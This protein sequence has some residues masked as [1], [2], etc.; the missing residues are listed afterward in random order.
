MTSKHHKIF[1]FL[2]LLTIFTT[3]NSA[4]NKIEQVIYAEFL[5]K[6]NVCFYG[7]SDSNTNDYYYKIENPNL[8]WTIFIQYSSVNSF[9]LYDSKLDLIK[10]STISTSTFNFQ[11]D[12]NIAEYYLK[13]NVAPNSKY[14]FCYI[15]YPEK[16]NKIEYK[17]DEN[18]AYASYEI[19]TP[20]KFS[21]YLP[22]INSNFNGFRILNNNL[23]NYKK[24]KII[25]TG[26]YNDNS[27]NTFEIKD[28]FILKDYTYFPFKLTQ[29][30]IKKIKEAY[31]DVYLEYEGKNPNYESPAELLEIE[32]IEIKEKDKNDKSSLEKENESNISNSL[33]RLEGPKKKKR[34]IA[35][36]EIIR[37]NRDLRRKQ[38]SYYY[39]GKIGDKKPVNFNVLKELTTNFFGEINR[40]LGGDVAYLRHFYGD[41][42]LMNKIDNTFSKKVQVSNDDSDL[43]LNFKTPF[44][45]DFNLNIIIFSGINGL[46]YNNV[47]DLNHFYLTSKRIDK[48]KLVTVNKDVKVADDLNAEVYVD[49]DG[50]ENIIKKK[51]WELIVIART[52]KIPQFF[53]LYEPYFNDPKKYESFQAK[54][55]LGD[56]SVGGYKFIAY[57][58]VF[59]VI[60][61]ILFAVYYLCKARVKRLFEKDSGGSSSFDPST[62]SISSS[63]S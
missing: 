10:T 31:L 16:A 24:Q 48:D 30:N 20:G 23:N 60:G 27:K 9:S 12:K 11:L 39:F 61:L 54:A 35:Y 51:D 40:S 56:T 25:F 4:P 47:C 2:C 26:I 52:P 15:M 28:N 36:Y 49:K 22:N 42:G 62:V 29:E 37:C 3:I 8:D 63:S 34:K 18:R 38:T 58:C 55:N 43:K 59:L 5:N 45:G 50:V 7:K 1:L 19:M 46:N 33:R 13:I 6:D 32:L 17:I 44:S 57:L 53:I 14:E 21:F 41:P